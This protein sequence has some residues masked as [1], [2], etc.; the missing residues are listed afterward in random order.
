MPIEMNCECGRDLYLRD[1]LAGKQ[2]R[3]P[4]CQRMLTVPY[5]G[6]PQPL[7]DDVPFVLPAPRPIPAPAPAYDPL[8]ERSE[9]P[10]PEPPPLPAAPPLPPRYPKP[11][12]GGVNGGKVIGGLAMLIAGGVMIGVGGAWGCNRF[13]YILIVIGIITFIKGLMGSRDD[14]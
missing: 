3:C 14:D 11:A 9:Q 5:A 13:P 4:D 1:D 6:R 2:I 7:H 8:A 10:K 12:G